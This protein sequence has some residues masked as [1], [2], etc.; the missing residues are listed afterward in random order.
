MIQRA[1]GKA[2]AY[3]LN[4]LIGCNHH[5]TEKMREQGILSSPSES[6][7]PPCRSSYEAK[8]EEAIVQKARWPACF[9]PGVFRG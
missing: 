5:C 2:F 4:V 8:Y 9:S 6:R 1:S 3:P 7:M